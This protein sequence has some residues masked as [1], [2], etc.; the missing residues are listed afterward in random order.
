MHSAGT[1]QPSQC[2]GVGVTLVTVPNVL[3]ASKPLCELHFLFTLLCPDVPA[4]CGKR[5]EEIT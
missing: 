3:W 5:E 4:P 1:S 2:L